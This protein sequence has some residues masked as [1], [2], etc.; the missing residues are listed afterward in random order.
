METI[1]RSKAAIQNV[2]NPQLIYKS[3]KNVT[4]WDVSVD[5]CRGPPDIEKFSAL[6]KIQMVTQLNLK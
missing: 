3:P 4:L 5:N 1:R 6:G 2:V